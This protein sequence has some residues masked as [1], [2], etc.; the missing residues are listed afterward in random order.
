LFQR[1]LERCVG[2]TQ[3]AEHIS[4]LYP[5]SAWNLGKE[6]FLLQAVDQLKRVAHQI[7]VR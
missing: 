4:S 7:V 5:F 1:N 6:T 2:Y 3:K